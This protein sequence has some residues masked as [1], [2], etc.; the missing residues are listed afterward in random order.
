ME[1]QLT[2]FQKVAEKKATIRRST[3][4]IWPV[5]GNLTSQ[6]GNRADPFN[7][8]GEVHLGLDI[9]AWFGTQVRSPAEGQVIYAQRKAADGNLIIVGHGNGVMTRLG[10][11][12]QFAGKAR[13]RVRK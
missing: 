2:L 8:E 5:K 7:G 4:T 9:G 6:Y 1:N 13:R 3:P 11:L 10:R 12:S